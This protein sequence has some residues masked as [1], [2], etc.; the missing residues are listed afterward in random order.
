M[1]AVGRWKTGVGSVQTDL[2]FK[3]SIMKVVG[4]F[5]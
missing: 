2:I 5:F 3:S 1:K 4:D